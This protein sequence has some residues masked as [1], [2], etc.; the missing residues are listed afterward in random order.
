MSDVQSGLGKHRC[1]LKGTLMCDVCGVGY[2]YRYWGALCELG[3]SVSLNAS[4]SPVTTL[5]NNSS[6]TAASSGSESENSPCGA[7]GRGTDILT[8]DLSLSPQFRGLV[9]RQPRRVSCSQRPL[10]GLQCQSH[11]DPAAIGC[12]QDRATTPRACSK[13][14]RETYCRPVDI[15][16]AVSNLQ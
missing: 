6:A 3:D 16:E 1:V 4:S 11:Q 5:A 8:R 14:S 13:S 15:S 2:G 9:P 10:S 12:L 7:R